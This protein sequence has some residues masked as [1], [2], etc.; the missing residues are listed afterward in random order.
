MSIAKEK[1]MI[2]NRYPIRE[3]SKKVALPI[4]IGAFFG[5]NINVLTITC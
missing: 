5:Y 3:F 2:K 4:D 1:K